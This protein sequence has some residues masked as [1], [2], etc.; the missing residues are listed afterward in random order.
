MLVIPSGT[1][2]ATLL[3]A[4]LLGEINHHVKSVPINLMILHF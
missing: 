3:L 4:D 1:F 2:G